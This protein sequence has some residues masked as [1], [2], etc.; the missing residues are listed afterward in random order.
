MEIPI[1][2]ELLAKIPNSNSSKRTVKCIIVVE[3]Y[4]NNESKFFAG[5]NH[6]IIGLHDYQCDIE[7]HDGTKINN[8]YTIHAESAALRE[9]QAYKFTSQI[10]EFTLLTTTAPCVECC[11]EIIL[12][13]KPLI[14]QGVKVNLI[15]GDEKSTFQNLHDK[16][17]C[18]KLIPF[19]VLKSANI[20]IQHNP[21][22]K[23]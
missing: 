14:N 22:L 17:K 5:Y 11:K 23:I 15:Y 3:F 16:T 21:N 7:I 6:S 9:Y 8:P 12:V 4:D 13:T 20:N 18:K 10:K 2:K 19:E 1:L